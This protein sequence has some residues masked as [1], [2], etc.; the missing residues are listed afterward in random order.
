MNFGMVAYGTSSKFDPNRHRRRSIRLR[1]YDYSRAGAYFITIC[2]HQ[3]RSLFGEVVKGEMMQSQL[4]QVVDRHWAYLA[5]HHWHVEL[6]EYIVMPNH[7]H[8]ILVLT[9]QSRQ[10]DMTE[11]IRGFKTFSARRI[12]QLRKLKGVPV[13]QRN[14]Y[15]RIVRDQAALDNIRRYI[16]NNPKNWQTDRLYRSGDAPTNKP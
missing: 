2:T 9:E 4:G 11:V 6:D 5:Q 16:R 13:W 10:H 12:N 3:R 15:E 14:Y 8:G 1:G 7:F